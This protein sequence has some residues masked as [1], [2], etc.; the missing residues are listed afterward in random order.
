MN[1]PI[2]RHYRLIL[3][4]LCLLLDL[5]QIGSWKVNR[6]RLALRYW[7]VTKDRPIRRCVNYK[8]SQ[9]LFTVRPHWLWAPR[10]HVRC[11]WVARTCICWH[12]DQNAKYKLPWPINNP[13]RLKIVDWPDEEWAKTVI[14]T[15]GV[16]THSQDGSLLVGFRKTDPLN[17]TCARQPILTCHSHISRGARKS[18]QLPGATDETCP[19]CEVYSGAYFP[20]CLQTNSKHLIHSWHTGGTL[21]KV[22]SLQN[23]KQNPQLHLHS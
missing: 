11:V 13:S 2:E 6:V 14:P 10:G 7:V 12:K 15:P 21:S 4:A 3:Q 18:R 23:C 16:P 5:L 8:H 20:Q 17:W 19:C 9:I 1:T 22:I